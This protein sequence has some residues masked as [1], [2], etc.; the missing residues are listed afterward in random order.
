M[1]ASEV[2]GRLQCPRMATDG[3]QTYVCLWSVPSNLPSWLAIDWLA[4]LMAATWR[5]W[6]TFAFHL[7]MQSISLFE[8]IYMIPS[9]LYDTPPLAAFWLSQV[10]Q[11]LSATAAWPSRSNGMCPRWPA[12][13]P[14]C[15]TCTT[16][17]SPMSGWS[18]PLQM[19]PAMPARS[20]TWIS[21]ATTGRIMPRSWSIWA[22]LWRWRPSWECC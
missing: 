21:T 12:G 8:S 18:V 22:R 4:L 16:W 6:P 15:S 20:K 19:A 17:A 7:Q 2:R 11:H 14:S 10:W 3:C 13:S 9:Q 5:F 1:A